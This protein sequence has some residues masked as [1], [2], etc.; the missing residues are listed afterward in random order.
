MMSYFIFLV[1]KMTLE[2]LRN[3][4]YFYLENDKVSEIEQFRKFIKFGKILKYF[5]C[6]SNFFKNNLKKFL[7]KII[8]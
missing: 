6:S 7:N 3:L 4:L 8:D 2:N 1:F 5:E